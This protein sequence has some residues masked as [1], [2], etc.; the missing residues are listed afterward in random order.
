[1]IGGELTQGRI[2]YLLRGKQNVSFRIKLYDD[3]L[4]LNVG[5]H[6]FCFALFMYCSSSCFHKYTLI[7]KSVCLSDWLNF[8]SLV[9]VALLE[10]YLPIN[11]Q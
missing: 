5:S 1:M 7:P 6:F 2:S 10:V 9:F 3:D 11:S 8:F 4:A